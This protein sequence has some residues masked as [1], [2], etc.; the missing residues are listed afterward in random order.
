LK[1]IITENGWGT[2]AVSKEADMM[3]TERCN[4]FRD[5]LGN[6]SAMA[7][8]EKYNV[9]GYTAW[10]VMDNYE[11][12]DGYHTRFG[13][14]Y[15][16]YQTMGRFPKMSYKWFQ[17]YVTPLKKLPTDGEPFHPCDAAEFAED[18]NVK[19]IVVV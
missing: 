1:Y 10:S 19:A 14:V 7:V 6:L 18:T 13:M 11:W 15:V 4:F 8:K 16:D 2:A 17:K 9:V 5:Y 12:A 3:D